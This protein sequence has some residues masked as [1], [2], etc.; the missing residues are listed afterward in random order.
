MDVR[1]SDPFAEMSEKEEHYSCSADDY[2]I[3]KCKNKMFELEEKCRS[4]EKCQIR[5]GQVGC[6]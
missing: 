3:L 1:I 5:G 2:A 6:Y 4:R